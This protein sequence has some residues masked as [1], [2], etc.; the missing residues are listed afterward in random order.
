M[1]CPSFSV[2]PPP[3]KALRSRPNSVLRVAAA[4]LPALL[5]AA[6]GEAKSDVKPANAEPPVLVTR[7][8]YAPESTTRSFTA[9][10]RPRI[11]TD[12]G[13]RVAGKVA[14]RLVDVGA[15]VKAGQVLATLDDTDLKLQL[16]QAQAEANAARISLEQT[17][18][19]EARSAALLASG[20]TAQAAFDR[21]HASTEEARGRDRRAERAVELAENSLAYAALKSDSD[22]V[23]TATF[24]E[25][26]QVVAV[27][28]AAIRVARFGEK[29]ALVA[30]PE[31]Q[32]DLA[33]RGEARVTLW[34]APG[35]SYAAHLRELAPAADPT[36]RTY[37]AR[38]SIPAADDAVA[39]GMSATLTLRDPG[40]KP[41][42]KVPLSALFNQ[43]DGPALWQV[44]SDGR[45]ALQHV[46][47]ARYDGDAAYVAS[48]IPE[49]ATI[50]T[51]GV[52]KLEPQEKVRAVRALGF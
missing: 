42:A 44:E 25:P 33:R 2:S 6:C 34:S 31:S 52:Q 14:R 35:R 40:A 51:L 48:G 29:E 43:G 13:F 36:T 26:G 12:Q 49:G 18:A 39:L 11:E 1:P 22:G 27:G 21:Q 19:D 15:R 45:L 20:W 10:I 41:V 50:V 37:A 9:A 28:Q 3:A 4:A 5:L 8:H 17:M 47:I 16:D 24:I 46:A 38:F 32:L 7:L 30:I 23:V